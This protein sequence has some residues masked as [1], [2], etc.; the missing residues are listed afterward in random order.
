MYNDKVVGIY[1]LFNTIIKTF[2]EIVRWLTF[3]YDSFLENIAT[4]VGFGLI[5]RNISAQIFK[6]LPQALFIWILSGFFSV[7]VL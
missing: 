2:I 3:V 4:I 7:L 5:F 1:S 6:N